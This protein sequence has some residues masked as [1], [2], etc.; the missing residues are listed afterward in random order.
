MFVCL[1]TCTY[2]VYGVRVRVR[3][4]VYARAHVCECVCVYIDTYRTHIYLGPWQR[5]AG[6]GLRQIS[7]RRPV[8]KD[9]KIGREKDRVSKKDSQLDR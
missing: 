4:C 6:V 7:G 5:P 9:K 3:V 8:V 2:C 1:Y